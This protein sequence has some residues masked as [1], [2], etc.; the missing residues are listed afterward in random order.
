MMNGVCVH[1]VSVCDDS[2]SSMIDTCDPLSGCKF[3]LRLVL[4][5]TGP[6]SISLV[7]SDSYIYEDY[8]TLT[9]DSVLRIMDWIKAKVAEARIPFCW[10]RS[11][12]RGI[13]VPVSACPVGKEKI[14]ALCYSYC[15]SGFGRFGF[16]CHQ[17]CLPG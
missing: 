13:G 17:N 14:G 6:D 9:N 5:E 3:I 8:N 10:K 4:G 11:Y 16:D 12:D 1:E 15:P 2:D 7:S